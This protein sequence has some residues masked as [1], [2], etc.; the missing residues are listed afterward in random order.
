MLLRIWLC[1]FLHVQGFVA[2][3]KVFQGDSY[4]SKTQGQRIHGTV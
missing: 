2:L 3:F 4:I 1:L